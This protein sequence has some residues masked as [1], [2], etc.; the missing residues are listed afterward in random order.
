MT[1]AVQK[2]LTNFKW[3]IFGFFIDNYEDKDKGEA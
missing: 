2:I 1:A 3:E